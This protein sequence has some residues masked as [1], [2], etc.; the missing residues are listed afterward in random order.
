MGRL[1]DTVIALWV[2]AAP[3]SAATPYHTTLLERIVKASGITVADSLPNN[4]R[5]DSVAIVRSKPVYMLTNQWGEVEHI[6]YS[7]FNQGLTKYNENEKIFRFVE[8]YLLE[9]DLRL[10]EV[11]MQER[12]H[13]DQVTLVKGSLDVLRQVTPQTNIALNFEEIKR[14]MFRLTFTLDKNEVVLTIPADRQLLLGAN[15]IELEQMVLRDLPR[16]M[17]L[18]GENMIQDWSGASVSSAGKTLIVKGGIYMSNAIRGDLYLT[19]K[20]GKR[21]LICS[22]SSATRSISNIM[23]T[24]IFPK[25]LPVKFELNEYS[26]KRDTLDVTLQQWIAYGKGEQ[27]KFYFGVRS[28]TKDVLKGTLFAYNEKLAYTHMLTV[29]FPLDILKGADTPIRATAYVYIPLQHIADDF[30]I[31]EFNPTVYDED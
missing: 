4:T 20:R 19:V 22:P 12:M 23:L 2:M 10:D 7:L 5:I 26:N 17:S 24:G 6:G 30:F 28:R 31:E 27:C 3:L 25:E 9:L 13:I 29:D 15:S 16:M 1:L 14:K 21:Q 11:G 18:T 8:R